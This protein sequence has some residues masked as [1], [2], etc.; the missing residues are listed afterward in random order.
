MAIAEGLAKLVRA[1][2]IDIYAG[3]S[4]MDIST[5]MIVLYVAGAVVNHFFDVSKR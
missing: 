5:V 1:W 4:L 3:W 2:S